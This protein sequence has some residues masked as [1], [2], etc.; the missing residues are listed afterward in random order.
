MFVVGAGL[1]L[2]WFTTLLSIC[3]KVQVANSSL[4]PEMDFASKCIAPTQGHPEAGIATMGDLLYPLSNANSGD[5]RKR[6]AGK[7]FFL[8]VPHGEDEDINAEGHI[9]LSLSVPA[10]RLQERGRYT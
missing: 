5:V 8:G 3:M 2:V 7:R 9:A 1:S 10:K 4:F 6:I